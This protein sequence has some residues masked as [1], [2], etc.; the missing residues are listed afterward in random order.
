MLGNGELRV[1]GV[2]QG[3]ENHLYHGRVLVRPNGQTMTSLSAGRMILIPG[4]Y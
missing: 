1:L 3:D 4:I 2:R